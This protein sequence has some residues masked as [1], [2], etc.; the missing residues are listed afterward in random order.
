MYLGT[1]PPQ[2]PPPQAV[3][4]P[5]LSAPSGAPQPLVDSSTSMS[6]SSDTLAKQIPPEAL[7]A[8]ET[9]GYPYSSVP[10]Q[11][12]PPP[13]PPQPQL[14][15][16]QQIQQQLQQQ[17][18]QQQQPQQM[19]QY[20]S[21]PNAQTALQNEQ[22]LQY[23]QT[24]IHQQQQQTRQQIAQQQEIQKAVSF[25]MQQQLQRQQTVPQPPISVPLPPVAPPQ[26]PQQA[27]VPPPQARAPQY[28]DETLQDTPMQQEDP[29]PM[30]NGAF[31]PLGGGA[32]LLLED[33]PQNTVPR[34]AASPGS[35]AYTDDTE[36]MYWERYMDPTRF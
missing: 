5:A 9:A 28:K 30:S 8:S 35:A 24:L 17:L 31:S 16:Q 25:L 11:V 20:A 10:G 12:P 19:L 23:V 15:P 21:Q 6:Y 32:D 29:S 34:L 7:F 1:Q 27:V 2:M 4:G 18:Q 26:V 13:L 36:R 3:Y 14:Q 33:I 22:F